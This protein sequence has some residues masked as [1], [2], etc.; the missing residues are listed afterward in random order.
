MLG[1]V[2]NPSPTYP[3]YPADAYSQLTDP[4]WNPSGST[5]PSVSQRL[6]NYDGS[7]SG[8]GTAVVSAQDGIDPR[9]AGMVT[10]IGEDGYAGLTL[11][12]LTI[13]GV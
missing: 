10:L 9:G 11:I 6:V 7:W 8:T 5:R 4:R 2:R 3:R 12:H 1:L 13:P